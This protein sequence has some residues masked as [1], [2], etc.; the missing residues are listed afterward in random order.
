MKYWS[1]KDCI[2][3]F[4]I[5][6]AIMKSYHVSIYTTGEELPSLD[7]SNFFHSSELFHIIEASPGERP[8]MAVARDD[9]GK[10]VGHMLSF[11]R[12]RSSWLPPYFYTQGRI[13]GEG[14]YADEVS[15][16]KVFA[17]LLHALTRKFHRKLCFYIEFSDLSRKMFGYRYFRA[18]GYFPVNWQEV[19]NSLHSMNPADRLSER[20]RDRIKRVYGYGVETREAQTEDEVHAF[21]RLLNGFYRLKMRR[22]IPPESQVRQFYKSDNGRIFITLYKKRVIGG[23]VCVF[24]NGNAYLWYLASK[25]KIYAGLHPNLMTVWYTIQWSWQH[26]YQ[27]IYFLDVGLPFSKNPFREFI[28][29]FGGK[30]V[31]KYR[32]FKFT[33]K[34]INHLLSFIYRE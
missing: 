19:H 10:I 20:M 7:E 16:D 17:S 15:K 13:Y 30:P 25:R 32:W 24:S 4:I 2:K 31:A 3:E 27:H 11:I 1:Q 33:I 12:R 8:Y 18:E 9:S 34:W 6:F 28:L 23:S 22:I 21:Y 14:V 5:N 29:S 26:H